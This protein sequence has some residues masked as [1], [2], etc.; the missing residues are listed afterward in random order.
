MSGADAISGV[1]AEVTYIEFL[2]TVIVAR[3]VNTIQP[4]ESTQL[5]YV[6]TASYYTGTAPLVTVMNLSR[7]DEVREAA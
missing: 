3:P 7:P 4:P 5:S 1:P 2:N 6:T